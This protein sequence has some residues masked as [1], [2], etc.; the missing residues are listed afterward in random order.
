VSVIPTNSIPRTFLTTARDATAQQRPRRRRSC[1]QSHLPHLN[2]AFIA[3]GGKFHLV[4]LL[5]QL[6]DADETRQ[7]LGDVASESGL[8]SPFSASH[9]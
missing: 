3:G 5:S 6:R 1:S 9:R 4:M 2:N 7:K 8:M